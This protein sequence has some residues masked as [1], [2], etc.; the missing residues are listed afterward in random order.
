MQK[1][2]SLF[3]RIIN[4]VKRLVDPEGQFYTDLFINNTDWNTKGPNYEEELRWQI[5]EEFLQHA[6][7]LDG[8]L[9]NKKMQILDIGCGRGW[10]SNLLSGYG[11]VLGIEPVKNV[12][13]Y[14]KQLFPSLDIRTGTTK[15][16]LSTHAN[17]FD[18]VVCS[19]VIEHIPGSQKNDFV[20]DLSLL[21]KNKAFLVI[22][23]P[24]KDAEAEWKKYQDPGQPVEEWM[25]ESE[26]ENLFSN[27]GWAP[28]QHKRFSIRPGEK[29]PEVEI[30]QLWLF[31]KTS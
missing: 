9:S 4:K 21:S 7:S 27:A 1:K 12:A 3:Q 26:V 18:L 6:I 5:I 29:A 20:T 24:R 23:T 17:V 30:Y 19:E 2:R 14:A 22:T 10:L 11:K 28:L 13:R 31:Q 25:L 16:I 8:K 15:S